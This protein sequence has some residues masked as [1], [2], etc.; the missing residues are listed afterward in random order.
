MMGGGPPKNQ[1]NQKISRR[2]IK[3]IVRKIGFR[4]F[5][6]WS[7]GKHETTY[8]PPATTAAK[9]PGYEKSTQSR[10]IILNCDIY[11]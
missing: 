1:K 10:R 7:P 6:G 5:L 8:E 2:I 11:T 9:A 4:T 3:K